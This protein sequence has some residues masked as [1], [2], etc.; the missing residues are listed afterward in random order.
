MRFVQISDI[1][2]HNTSRHK[3]YAQVFKILIEKIKKLK[4][5]RII[6]T[7]D[8]F[9][10]RTILSPESITLCKLLFKSLA[11]IALLDIIMGNHD[12][13]ISNKERMNPLKMIISEQDTWEVSN[14]ITLYDESKVYD[15]NN[16]FSYGNFSVMDEDKYPVEV[17]DKDRINIAL[18]HGMVDSSRSSTNY[19]LESK[20]NM[21]M[22][23]GYD[24]GFF[25]DIHRPQGFEL[26]E[27]VVEETIDE[28][29]L[30]HYKKIYPDLEIIEE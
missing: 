27:H 24:F 12:V 26:T 19:I 6:I 11:N 10:L 17:E 7:G 4:P 5:D 21:S 8:I 13:V 22:F 25:G 9:C 3:E 18:Y 23:E 1:H 16:K 2:I 29:E 14:E 30:E 15:I 28:S 20:Y